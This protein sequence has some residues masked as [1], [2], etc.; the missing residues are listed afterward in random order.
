MYYDQG[1]FPE[2]SLPWQPGDITLKNLRN[3][4]FPQEG[5]LLAEMD[6]MPYVATGAAK[7]RRVSSRSSAGSD[8]GY[9]DDGDEEEL[10]AELG[11]L[12][13]ERSAAG[14]SYSY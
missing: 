4:D 14:G 12:D 1:T 8:F 13:E 7:R 6:G 11:R 10:R 5:E 9:S 2:T 3:V